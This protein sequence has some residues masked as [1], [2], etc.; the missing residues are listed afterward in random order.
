MTDLTFNPLS[1][2]YSETEEVEDNY[3]WTF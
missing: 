2:R 1:G 3:D